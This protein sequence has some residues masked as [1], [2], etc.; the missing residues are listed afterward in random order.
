MKKKWDT[1]LGVCK[2][3]LLKTNDRNPKQV[4]HFFVGLPNPEQDEK[5]A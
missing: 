5:I 1:V 3:K 2:A 4:G